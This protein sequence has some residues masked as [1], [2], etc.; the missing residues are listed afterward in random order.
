MDNDVETISLKGIR[1]VCKAERDTPLSITFGILNHAR[2]IC[3]PDRDSQ[4]ARSTANQRRSTHDQQPAT[5]KLAC[6]LRAGQSDFVVRL[7]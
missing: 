6:P 5:K 4:G 1:K 7:V 2:S 3:H